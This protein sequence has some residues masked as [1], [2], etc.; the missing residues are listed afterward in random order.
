M[1]VEPQG[2]GFSVDGAEEGFISDSEAFASVINVLDGVRMAPSLVAQVDKEQYYYLVSVVNPGRKIGPVDEALTVT[3]LKALTRAVF[4]IDI[5]YH[6]ALLNNIFL[7]S[8]WDYDLETRNAFLELITTMA[9]LPDKFLENCLHVLLCNF[10][11]PNWLKAPF[12][13]SKRWLM[14]KKEVHSELHL[15]LHCITTLVPLAPVRLKCLIEKLMSRVTEDKYIMVTYVEGLLGLE[16]NEIGKFLGSTVMAKVVDLLTDLDVNIPWEDIL[17]E[18]QN[19]SVFV[20]ELGDSNQDDE[21]SSI[22]QNGVLKCNVF[23]DKLDGL[24]VVVC[25]HLKSCADTGCLLE[26]FDRLSEIFRRAV[27]K[28]HK[29]KFTQFLIFYACSLDPDTCGLKFAIL[30]TD[31]FVS[32]DEDPDSRMKAVAYLASYLS[33]AKFISSSLVTSI[34]QRLVDWCFEYC[35]LQESREK[36]ISPQ[37]DRIFY[38]GCQAVMYILCFRLRS[39]S[40]VPHLKQLL[41]HLPLDS[42][43]CHP[44]LD[45]LKVCLPL[46]VQE[47]LRQAS[48]ARLFK[49]PMPYFYDD[50]FESEFSKAFGGIERLDMFFPFDPYLLKESDRFM[51]P[52]FEFWDNVR[53]TYSNFD[54]DEVDDELEDLDVPNF[55]DDAGGYE[56][57]NDI[58][59][60][61]EDDIE[62]PMSKMS[63]TPKPSFLHPIATNFSQPSLMPARI[64]PSQSPPSPRQGILSRRE[65]RG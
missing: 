29:S 48:A 62:L 37:A 51:R 59:F 4:K 24:M 26:G 43:L 27:L 46:I 56:V 3:A 12:C 50:S 6:G 11:P 57:H 54:G 19:K 40:D 34:L 18:E 38:S 5:M 53:T 32:K 8:I 23:A 35:Q 21:H 22:K 10:R 16:K 61:N 52:N 31:I 45:P 30:L 58:D 36:M 39:I 33:R 9:T 17:Q 20:I 42:I 25:D 13:H 55:P 49:K 65:W 2:N 64:R 41:F 28:L 44:T 1:G 7:T 47:F 60:D 63:I 14:R 15:A